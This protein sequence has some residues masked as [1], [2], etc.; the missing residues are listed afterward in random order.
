MLAKTS[1]T[2]IVQALLLYAHNGSHGLIIAQAS[3][4]FSISCTGTCRD[5]SRAGGVIIASNVN[6]NVGDIGQLWPLYHL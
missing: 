5:I 1:M 2:A 3:K 4:S 6:G